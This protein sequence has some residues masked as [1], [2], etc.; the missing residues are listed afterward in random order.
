MTE[1]DKKNK[2]DTG[3]SFRNTVLLSSISALLFWSGAYV[4]IVGFWGVILCSAPLAII[5]FRDGVKWMTAGLISVAIVIYTAVNPFWGLYFL[6]GEGLLCYGLV[7]PAKKSASGAESLLYCIL[8][9]VFS[10]LVWVAVIFALT[11]HNPIIPDPALMKEA[12]QQMYPDLFLETGAQAETIK[13]AVDEMMAALPYM[14]PSLLL[15]L[16]GLDSFLNYKLCEFLQK[17]HTI[18]LLP[19]PAFKNW[20]FPKSLV[21]PMLLSFVLPLLW[22]DAKDTPGLVMILNFNLK[23]LLN[24]FFFLQGVSFIWWFFC[25]RKVRL[26]YRVLVISL[27]A[28]PAAWPFLSF[29]GI[30][31]MFMDFRKRMEA[32][33]S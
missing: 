25:W 13:K 27:S 7:I 11:G 2:N 5:G 3:R 14:L 9:S 23:L 22:E 4:S 32:A 20:R 6:L 26:I 17:K 8:V 1:S 19:L 15:I 31:D 28:I 33:K 30:G 18:K 24:I 21:W 29:L 16:A 10:K 12:M